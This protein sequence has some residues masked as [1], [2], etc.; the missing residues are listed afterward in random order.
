MATMK[1][2]DAQLISLRYL[3]IK[4]RYGYYDQ[5]FEEY[6]LK[7]NPVPAEPEPIAE[8]VEPLPPEQEPEPIPS[9]TISSSEDEKPGILGRLFKNKPEAKD[10]FVD[11]P[12][13]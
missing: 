6:V 1:E 9:T 4:G 3:I 2:L 13:N 5:E 11:T 12:A 8:T 10:G 7:H